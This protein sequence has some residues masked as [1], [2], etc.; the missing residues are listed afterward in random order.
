MLAGNIV[1]GC[2]AGAIP[3]LIEDGVNGFIFEADNSNALMD[4]IQKVLNIRDK[5]TYIENARRF[6]EK[7]IS[8][9]TS[10]K[11]CSLIEEM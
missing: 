4:V 6:A 5:S 9:N 1:I 3:E 7:F 8:D 2:D 10:C 11:I